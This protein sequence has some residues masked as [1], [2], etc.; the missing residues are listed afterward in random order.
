MNARPRNPSIGALAAAAALVAG[1]CTNSSSEPAFND[2]TA[3]YR[4]HDG[5]VVHYAVP[6][7][8]KLRE[9]AVTTAGGRTTIRIT[10]GAA[11]SRAGGPL[12]IDVHFSDRREVAFVRDFEYPSRDAFDGAAVLD[13]RT[14]AVLGKVDVTMDGNRLELAFDSALVTGQPRIAVSRYLPSRAALGDAQRG[15]EDAYAAMYTF[16]TTGTMHVAVPFSRAKRARSVDRAVEQEIHFGPPPGTT[17]FEPTAPVIQIPSGGGTID[18]VDHDSHWPNDG[19]YD[20]GYADRCSSRILCS[21]FTWTAQ[22]SFLGGCGGDR[23]GDGQLDGNELRWY[24]GFCAFPS[25]VNDTWQ[26]EGGYVYWQNVGRGDNAGE[27]F[28]YIMAP[29]T[30]DLEVWY[31][32]NLGRTWAFV[33]EGLGRGGSGGWP[34]FPS[35][36]PPPAACPA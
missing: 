17:N 3:A 35:P 27:V 6:P 12:A 32:T 20:T 5:R 9:V 25:A 16:G 15:L 19:D 21:W 23:D 4:T 22:V 8:A 7:E 13:C 30:G 14:G 18:V 10:T 28:E 33:Y 1:A 36:P 2:E 11:M 24:F 34:F 31:S 29:T 26:D